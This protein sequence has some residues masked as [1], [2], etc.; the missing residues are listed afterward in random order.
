M[1][2]VL[3]PTTDQLAPLTPF[4]RRAFKMVDFVN[5]HPLSKEMAQLYLKTFGTGWVYYCSRNLT[6]IIGLDNIRELQPPRGL[7]LASN[8]RSF[9]DQYFISCWLFKTTDLLKRIYFPVRSEFFYERPLGLAVS[10][11]MSAFCMYPPVFRDSSKRDFNNYS[12]KRIVQLLKE[13]G[14]VVGVHPEGTRNKG[15]DPYT[16]LRAQPGIGKLILDAQPMVIPIFINGLGNDFV[17]QVKDNF[18]G[19]GTPVVMI[20]G[21]P[22]DLSSF[23][24]K[25]NRLRTQKEVADHVVAEIGKLGPLERAYRR[26]LEAHPERGPVIC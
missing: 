20:V 11:V 5:S 10:M 15:D 23:F 2:E 26:R 13:Q 1:F 17:Q 19:N 12:V 14:S 21:E 6:H 24:A 4:E 8:H 9:F 3:T 18:N 16:L 25:P 7:L 22:L